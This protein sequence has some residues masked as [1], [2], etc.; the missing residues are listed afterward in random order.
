MAVRPRDAELWS[1]VTRGHQIWMGRQLRNSYSQVLDRMRT[2]PPESNAESC[3]SDCWMKESTTQR[4]HRV[5]DAQVSSCQLMHTSLPCCEAC[6]GSS[7][8]VSPR[9]GEMMSGSEWH[10]PKARSCDLLVSRERMCA[11][12]RRECRI[13]CPVVQT[14]RWHTVCRRE[15]AL[16]Y[17]AGH[18]EES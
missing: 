3:S 12:L 17:D 8:K 5:D 2:C 1:E 7:L 14:V 11:S 13:P 15:N 10:T 4:N 18:A 16:S 9:Q 6:T